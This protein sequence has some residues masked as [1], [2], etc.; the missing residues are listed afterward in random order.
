MVEKTLGFLADFIAPPPPP[1]K[2]QAERMQQAAEERG[3]EE[4]TAREQ[5]EKDARLREL[6]DQMKR[7][8]EQARYDRY[9]GRSRDDDDYDRGRERERER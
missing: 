5:A 8:D 2:D 7:D 1:T 9:T 6:L 3:V 4:A